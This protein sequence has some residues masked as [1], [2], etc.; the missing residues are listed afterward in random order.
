MPSSRLTK[1]L[2]EKAE[3]LKRRRQA[4]E[5]LAQQATDRVR[6]FEQADIELPEGEAREASLKELIRHSDWDG[7]EAGARG[8]L[9]YLD[10]EGGP[11]LDQRRQEVRD[12]VAR[13]AEVGFP[14][15]EEVP[16]LLEESIPFQA[17]G[18]WREAIDRVLAVLEAIKAGEA[19]YADS[20]E[21]QFRH[22]AEWAGESPDH[23]AVAGA[24]TRPI[25]ESILVGRGGDGLSEYYATLEQELPAVAARRSAARSAAEALV[26]AARELGVPMAEVEEVLHKEAA[27]VITSVPDRVGELELSTHAASDRVRER[28]AQTIEGYRAT[29]KE[30][31]EMST[32]SEAA[33]AHLES[34]S[35]RV[36]TSPVGE[37]LA[38]LREAREITEEPVV[39]VVAGLLDEVRPK[40]VEA[41]RLGRNSSEVFAAMNRAREALRLKIYGEALAASRQAL[42][43]VQRLTEDL[44]TAREES[45][46]LEEL[47]TQLAPGRFPAEPFASALAEIREYLDRVELGRAQDRLR[48]TVEA[49]G[50]AAVQFF[51]AELVEIDG[52]G[53]QARELGFLPEP[54]PDRLEEVRRRLEAGSL[55]EVAEGLARLGV[56]LRTAAQPFVARRIE[57]IGQG[58]EEIRDS[59]LVDPVRR[60]LA[61]TD[62]TLRVKEDL[63][64]SLET[65]H[66]AEREF[67]F[68]FAQNASA[69]VESLEEERRLLESMGGTGDEIQRQ[70]DEVQQIFNMGDFVKAFRAAQEIRTRARQQQL[71][72][73]EE[74]LSHTKL[75]LVELSQLGLD[76]MALRATLDRGTEAA[77]DGRY[78]DAYT[79][80]QTTLDAAGRLKTTGLAI[81]GR[82]TEV[83]EL[84]ETLRK[85][86]VDVAAFT[87]SLGHARSACQALDF[88]RAR[89]ISDGLHEQLDRELAR[90]EAGRLLTDAR[91][92]VEDGRR[93]SVP[94][95][96]YLPRIDELA[97]A[98]DAG[99]TRELWNR[100]RGIHNELVALIRSVLE[101]NVRTLERDVD[102]A[103]TAELDVGQT[104]ELLAEIRR[105]LALPVPLG[106]A[107]VLESARTRFFETKGFLEHAER[108]ARRARESLNRAEIVRVDIRPF[109]PR[110][111]RIERHLSERDYA[112]T[113]DLASTLERELTQAT[114]Q[115]VS[116][117][118]ASF[119]GMLT[120]ARREHA[121]TTL[122][123]NLLEQARHALEEGDPLQALTL[124]AR[125]EGELERVELQVQVAQSSLETIDRHLEQAARAGLS[126]P[127]ATHLLEGARAAFQSREY[128]RVLES[129]LE[130]SDALATARDGLR[131]ARESIESAERQVREASELN[132]E[133]GDAL[134][135]LEQAREL[136]RSGQYALS[137]R[138]AREAGDLSRWAIE[139]LYSGPVAELQEMIELV[140]SAGTEADA[141][142]V[143][144]ARDDA[145]AALKVRDWARATETLTRGRAAA[146]AALDRAVEAAVR[147]LDVV[148]AVTADPAAEEAEH[149]RSLM[150]RVTAE[151]VEHHHMAALELLR[152]EES[153][154]RE[155]LRRE[156][157]RRVSELQDHL[158]IGE[159]IG[160][161]TTPVMQVFSEAKLALEAGRLDPIVPLVQRGLAS[162]EVLVQ[163]R[164]EEKLREVET[165]IV[166]ARDGLHVTTGPVSEKYEFARRSLA[167]HAPLDAARALL[168]AEEE[169]S[170]RKA[171][172]RE[173]MNLNFLIDAALSRAQDRRLDT[174]AARRLLD[175]SVRARSEEYAPALEKA[176]EA[177]RLLQEA[178]EQA[179]PLAALP[180]AR[181]GR[182]DPRST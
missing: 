93:L 129:A 145:D 124:A 143:R 27:A 156:L 94:V 45:Q 41:R 181:G 178:L 70:I 40:L 130:A 51:Q 62:V 69:M 18:K 173:L 16:P 61:D 10:L 63:K 81:L 153:R 155:E 150:D 50:S 146:Y 35:L 30:M 8:F 157:A 12:R 32:L 167:G 78:P 86:G 102:I 163:Q 175:E 29:L 128:P 149:R 47:L 54:F 121:E 49:L 38:L 9:A 113:I 158:W 42:E 89:L 71:L 109:R 117:T 25:I 15:A 118:L 22:L 166:F 100:S 142:T 43:E 132:A 28:L 152:E 179:D 67:S 141:Q 97:L 140:R 48:E 122:A 53:R 126:A 58:L 85:S 104:V 83:T 59:Q 123:E 80:A 172:H 139:R 13:L 103:R 72:R 131:R 87:D 21:G 165:E 170:R 90:F 137:V 147:S 33:L 57:E 107:E 105:R 3:L 160:V 82:I 159:K 115:Q 180:L 108:V 182:L 46:A 76:T 84:W 168:E 64:G 74:A 154:A 176:R 111:E 17:E 127:E 23:V 174:A 144:S 136:L 19:K 177:L 14:L 133:L 91:A 135:V 39:A 5:A 169:L 7:V 95:D 92:L 171:L 56:E 151:R 31:A 134:P 148:Y 66:R 79:I 24:R 65:L 96:P 88:E 120:R 98:L 106:V 119:Q 26:G 114:H 4:A 101:E 52:L 11:R 116:K 20:L 162:L 55:A 77:R 60:L 1:I 75:A 164:I 138:R 2:Q 44:D 36:P 99:G 112:R 110:L 68:A 125:S 161:D 34:V 6:E 37:L 73:S